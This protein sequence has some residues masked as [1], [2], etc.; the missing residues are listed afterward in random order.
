MARGRR[1]NLYIR[2]L[3]L[4][5]LFDC[6]RFWNT[7]YLPAQLHVSGAGYKNQAKLAVRCVLVRGVT[8][9]RRDRHG[10][11]LRG[12]TFLPMIPAWRTRRE[13]F[14]QL[15]IDLA[16]LA[17]RHHSEVS[18]I[19]FGV[20]DVPPSDPAE[21]ESSRAVL[22]RMFP[23]DKSGRLPCRIVVYR[24]PIQWR[25]RSQ[26]E[27]EQAVKA[28]LATHLS[29]EIGCAPEDIFPASW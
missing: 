15:V 13:K 12:V 25:C 3:M 23:A 7:F 27:M 20:E 6:N 2:R 17:A 29:V 9:S 4:R 19:E 26:A 21:W 8:R 28:V 14:D 22:G 5:P 16:T 18:Q 24:L 10:R 1:W 11:G